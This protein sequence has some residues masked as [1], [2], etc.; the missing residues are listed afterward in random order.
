M[1]VEENNIIGEKME[2][3]SGD[4]SINVDIYA[5]DTT[6]ITQSARSIGEYSTTYIADV[7]PYASSL[8][9]KDEYVDSSRSI[10]FYKTIYYQKGSNPTTWKIT[11]VTGSATTNPTTIQLTNQTLNCENS[12]VYSG[13]TTS[14]HKDFSLSGKSFDKSLTSYFT[15]ASYDNGVSYIAV[16]AN[17]NGKAKTAGGSTWSFNFPTSL[18]SRM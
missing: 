14:Q 13:H 11:R 10:H 18:V 15:Q 12:S 8:N 4:D 6:N 17:W 3:A 1:A 7:T 16:G 5:I 9:L 2:L